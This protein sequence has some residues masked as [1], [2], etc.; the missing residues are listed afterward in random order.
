[1][2]QSCLVLRRVPVVVGWAGNIL[3]ARTSANVS[4]RETTLQ[5][6][7]VEKTLPSFSCLGSS[8]FF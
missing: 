4:W 2:N 6:S 7:A 5:L 3:S 1:M 8:C